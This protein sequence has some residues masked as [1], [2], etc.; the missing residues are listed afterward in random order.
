MVRFE[1]DVGAFAG[2]KQLTNCARLWYV[3]VGKSEKVLQVPMMPYES[4]EQEQFGRDMYE[5]QK[6]TRSK[7]NDVNCAFSKDTPNA[8]NNTHKILYCTETHSCAAVSVDI[9]KHTLVK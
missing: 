1:L 2:V 8:G 5:M 7:T 3:P 6:A 4:P 9:V